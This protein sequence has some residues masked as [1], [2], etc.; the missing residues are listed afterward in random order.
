M[1]QVATFRLRLREAG[2][3]G[4]PDGCLV[5]DCGSLREPNVCRIDACV[6]EGRLNAEYVAS[7]ITFAQETTPVGFE[8]TRGDPIGLAGRRLNR[9]AK[10][11]LVL[12][13]RRAVL[14]FQ[15]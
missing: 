12:K 13:S 10:V 6:C 11:S 4:H 1:A 14:Q 5:G 15:T 7:L 3:C 8:P 2:A 9:S